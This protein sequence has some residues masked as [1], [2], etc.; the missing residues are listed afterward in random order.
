MSFTSQ[1]EL[2]LGV[3]EGVSDVLTGAP[4]LADLGVTRLTEFEYMGGM[5]AKQRSFMKFYEERFGSLTPPALPLRS[6]PLVRG[7]FDPKQAFAG[8]VPIGFYTY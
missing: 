6:P 2:Y 8:R 4:T 1:D 3:Q 7:Q 5:L